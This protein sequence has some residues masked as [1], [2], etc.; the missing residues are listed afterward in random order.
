MIC[1]KVRLSSTAPNGIELVREFNDAIEC[2]KNS[3]TYKD[4]F[5]GLAHEV[6]DG[7]AEYITTNADLSSDSEA[8]EVNQLLDYFEGKVT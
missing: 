6:V 4:Y 3:V 7:V 8:P 1:Y 2:S 5:G